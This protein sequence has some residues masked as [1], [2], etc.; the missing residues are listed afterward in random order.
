MKIRASVV[1]LATLF[2]ATPVLAEEA[3]PDDTISFE[4]TAEDWVTTKTAHV[5]LEVEA[6]VNAAN[7]GAIRAEMTKAVND[8]AKADWRLTSFNRTQ[9]QTGLERWSMVF[10]ARLPESSLNG[11]SEAAK[12]ASKAG[13]QIK[14]GNVDF[15]PSR[16]EMEAARAALR[17]KIYKQAGEQLTA[18]N[19]TLP[20][21]AY[22]LA[23]IV[24]DGRG[25]VRMLRTKNIAAEGAMAASSFAPDSAMNRDVSSKLVLGAQVV[26]AA[27]PPTPSHP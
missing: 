22:R 7:A 9:D 2:F 5:T 11:L 21:R 1:L 27:V 23:K 19:S 20:G 26:F 17:T 8:A 14:I 25:P 24:F 18:L 4:L 13:M 3:K 16:E 15:Q 6:A 12:K 10:E